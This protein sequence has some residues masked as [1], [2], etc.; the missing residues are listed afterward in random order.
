MR[1]TAFSSRYGPFPD[2]ER[3]KVAA[4]APS[5]VP[6]EENCLPGVGGRSVGGS[7]SRGGESSRVRTHSAVTKTAASPTLHNLLVPATGMLV[8]L[9]SRFYYSLFLASPPAVEEPPLSLS[10][11]LRFASVVRHEQRRCQRTARRF[12]ELFPRADLV[13]ALCRDCMSDVDR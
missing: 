4:L 3:A 2:N 6:E 5:T 10:L 9:F 8:V 12:R 13:N 7:G 1:V 11:S